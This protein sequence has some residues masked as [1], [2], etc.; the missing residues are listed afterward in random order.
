MSLHQ[1]YQP[2]GKSCRCRKCRKCR[3]CGKC[4]KLEK[5]LSSDHPTK[6]ISESPKTDTIDDV[7]SHDNLR[8]ISGL[9]P[10]KFITSVNTC[11]EIKRIDFEKDNNSLFDDFSEV[12]GDVNPDNAITFCAD[13]K[14]DD[15]DIDKIKYIQFNIHAK[16]SIDQDIGIMLQLVKV[17]DHSKCNDHYVVTSY[18]TNF[19]NYTFTT[20]KYTKIFE[21]WIKPTVNGIKDVHINDEKVEQIFR[22]TMIGIKGS[23]ELD[24]DFSLQIVHK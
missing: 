6:C 16:S 3:K 11:T 21:R 14:M 24:Q 18:S 8:V 7:M 23:L 12:I 20:G 1:K 22:I 2:F 10:H 9:I 4:R 15:V 5:Y 13:L 19:H 17:A